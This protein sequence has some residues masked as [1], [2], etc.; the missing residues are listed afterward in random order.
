MGSLVETFDLVDL[1]AAAATRGHCYINDVKFYDSS[2]TTSYI[3]IFII[4]ILV[5][6]ME[7]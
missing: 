6:L 5:L 3:Y 2:I 7:S 4:K 1:S